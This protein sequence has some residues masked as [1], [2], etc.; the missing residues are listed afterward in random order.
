MTFD[1]FKLISY[2]NLSDIV[3]HMKSSTSANDVMPTWFVKAN[4]DTIGYDVLAIIN[5]S[6]AY[7]TVLNCFKQ[8]IVQPLL[9]KHNLD[10]NNLTIGPYLNCHF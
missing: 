2:S 7:G 5:Y 1:C 10:V 3:T 8:A 4:F 9:K 6:L